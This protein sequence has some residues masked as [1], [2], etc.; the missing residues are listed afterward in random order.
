MI[1]ATRVEHKT[2][3]WVSFK[4]NVNENKKSLSKEE[5]INS[6]KNKARQIIFSML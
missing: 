2:A 6:I 1:K 5:L 3:G 4:L